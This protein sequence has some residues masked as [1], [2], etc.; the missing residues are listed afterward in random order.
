VLKKHGKEALCR[1]SKIKHST[2]KLF[3]EC[4]LTECF[5][6]LALRKEPDSG[7]D[8]HLSMIFVIEIRR[9]EIGGLESEACPIHHSNI[10]ARVLAP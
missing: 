7:S 5:F 6:C 9:S 10:F 1:V 8:G 3:V 2:N 4:F